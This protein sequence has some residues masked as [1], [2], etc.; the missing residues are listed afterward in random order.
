MVLV[1]ALGP[2]FKLELV[3]NG[4]F[5][6]SILALGAVGVSL[7]HG[8]LR[9]THVAQGEFMT[10]GAYIS[11]FLLGTLFPKIG[12]DSAGLGPFTFGF[13]LLI[14]IPIT[15]A[16]MASMAVV[17][18]VV[19]YRRLRQRRAKL[20]LLAV[21]SLGVAVALRGLVQTIWGSGTEQLPQVPKSIY[22]LPLG[23]QVPPDSIFIGALSLAS[24]AALYLFLTR[25]NLGRTMR[26]ATSNAGP[27]EA[28]GVDTR[29]LVWATWGISAGLAATAGVLLSVHQGQLF[30]AMGWELLLPLFAAAIVGGMSSP[31]GAFAGALAI[32]VAAE[33][34]TEWIDASY[35]P[36][37]A[38]AFLIVVMLVLPRGIFGVR[39]AKT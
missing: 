10:F 23:V 17:L 13:P 25:S 36:A 35:R 21:A 4:L 9:F 3:V 28:G 16:A 2:V 30:P 19:V 34:S 31:Y 29:H 33:V 32:G 6:G 39:M 1:L 20:A 8:V 11:F 5:L 24:L 7:V 15:V 12:M 27:A 18:D 14:A 26:E 22:Q 37:V 38:F